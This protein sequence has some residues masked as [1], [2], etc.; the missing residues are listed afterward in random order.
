MFLQGNTVDPQYAQELSSV[1]AGRGE[2]D[3]LEGRLDG[4]NGRAG[5]GQSRLS[6]YRSASPPVQCLFPPCYRRSAR[7]A[8]LAC[9]LCIECNVTYHIGRWLVSACRATTYSGGPQEV[10]RERNPDP[11]PLGPSG[12]RLPHPSVSA[13]LGFSGSAIGFIIWTLGPFATKGS[14]V[15]VRF[16]GFRVWR[17][18]IC[19]VGFELRGRAS[20]FR[21]FSF[22]LWR[23]RRMGLSLIA[24]RVFPA[25]TRALWPWTGPV[26][27]CRSRGRSSRFLG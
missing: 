23:D 9:G 5:R 3:G 12:V 10:C 13:P 17:L 16:G 11:P 7:R 6:H 1:V 26:C 24:L 21:R 20:G 19:D 22:T 4:L 27:V 25:W 8:V 18:G 14:R 2:C 15:F